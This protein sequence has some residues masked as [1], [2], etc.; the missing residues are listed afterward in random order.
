MRLVALAAA[1][2]ILSAC[3]PSTT[4]ISD[5]VFAELYLSE[6]EE[7]RRFETAAGEAGFELRTVALGAVPSGRE[8]VDAALARVDPG[9][10][11]V[12]SPLLSGLVSSSDG[13][14]DGGGPQVL[15]LGGP[16]DL[17][18][19]D[20]AVSPAGEASADADGNTD[21][22]VSRAVYNRVPAF[23]ELGRRVGGNSIVAYFRSDTPARRAE[24]DA[25]RDG[26]GNGAESTR[27]VVFESPP[28]DSAVREE[29]FRV[30]SPDVE[31]V[32]AFLGSQNR[33]VFEEIRGMGTTPP[34][35]ATEDLGPAAA[36]DS[37]VS[38]SIER[39]Y[40]AAVESFLSG[41]RGTIIVDAQLVD[42]D[43]GRNDR[44]P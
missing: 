17:T 5:P 42:R 1:V 14:R 37:F 9:Q 31:L 26:L 38:Y 32:A 19:A 23:A 34:P 2:T 27:F 18:G 41:R 7:V 24:L 36:Y 30:R 20:I 12:L 22:T 16:D 25:F 10:P 15:L 8:A 21:D 43:V 44:V 4:L 3:T 6:Q 33:L 11:T 39:D 40:A 28:D 13:S 29:L 35:V